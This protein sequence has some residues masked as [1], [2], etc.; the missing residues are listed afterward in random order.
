MHNSTTAGETIAG[1]ALVSI[2]DKLEWST[3]GGSAAVASGSKAVMG[4]DEI[5][6]ADGTADNEMV[7]APG[8]VT[9]CCGPRA[10]GL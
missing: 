1:C 7:V 9:S 2:F 4:G 10:G 3:D 8:V 6:A 5:S